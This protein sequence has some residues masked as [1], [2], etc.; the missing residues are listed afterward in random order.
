MVCLSAAG[1]R[2]QGTKLMMDVLFNLTC[3]AGLSAMLIY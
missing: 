1:D 2:S 3:I